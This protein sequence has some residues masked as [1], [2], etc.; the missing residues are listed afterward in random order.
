MGTTE[1]KVCVKCCNE[2]D[3]NGATYGVCPFCGAEWTNVPDGASDLPPGTM[4]Y[5]YEIIRTLGYG[6]MGTVYLAEQKSMQRQIALKVLN[7]SVTKD[8]AAVNQF[9]NEVRNTGQ[10]HH[11]NIVNAFDAGCENG[12]YFFAMQYI[13][14]ETLDLILQERKSLPEKEAL[15]ITA[16]I[17]SALVYVW[18]KHQMFHRDIKPGN[19]M[20]DDDGKAMLMDLG[21]AQ[22]IGEGNSNSESI[23]GSPYY[24]SP[25]QIQGKPLSWSTDLYSLGATLYQLITGVPPYDDKTIE[26]ILKKHCQAEFPDPAERAPGASIS[27]ET[28]ALL[29]RMMNKVPEKRFSSWGEFI[30]ELNELIALLEDYEANPEKRKVMDAATIARLKREEIKKKK[31]KSTVI[32]LS[33]VAFL[34]LLCVG[35]YIYIATTNSSKAGEFLNAVNENRKTKLDMAFEKFKEN[36]ESR[37]E[38]D[39]AL[40]NVEILANAVGVSA[41]DTEQ[42]MDK[43]RNRRAEVEKLYTN[44]TDFVKFRDEEFPAR[45]KNIEEN[46]RALASKSKL[47]IDDINNVEGL[48]RNAEKAINQQKPLHSAHQQQLKGFKTKI[49]YLKKEELNPFR[50][51]LKN[52]DEYAA[53]SRKQASLANASQIQR[54][55]ENS[56][57]T[58]QRKANRQADDANEKTRQAILAKQKAQDAARAK[59]LNDAKKPK[60]PAAA[61]RKAP[62]KKPLLPIRISQNRLASAEAKKEQLRIQNEFRDAFALL[63][64]KRAINIKPNPELLAIKRPSH[65]KALNTEMDKLL[66]I[67]EPLHQQAVDALKGWDAL[68]NETNQIIFKGMSVSATETNAE[69][70]KGILHIDRIKYGNVY[71]SETGS[72]PEKFLDLNMKDKANLARRLAQIKRFSVTESYHFFFTFGFYNLAYDACPESE[73][74]ILQKKIIDTVRYHYNLAKKRGDLPTQNRMKRDYQGVKILKSIVR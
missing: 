6:G 10:I 15:A 45:K 65:D 32:A 11:P 69:L 73:Q 38:I 41:K 26:G 51:K 22:R 49:D 5:G 14:G 7:N 53:K 33:L 17:A 59:I 57:L 20:L 42:I 74:K 47:S 63:D 54:A 13:K 64:L 35:G 34:V 23:E 43:V 70:R 36:P 62:P 8:T 67:Y 39:K 19:I 52:Q 46:I 12:I 2:F 56:V 71:F 58:E 1:K 37:I 40:K 50:I 18:N 55:T 3:Y 27:Y 21:I 4:L 16:Q 28:V 30:K 44:F 68:N 61:P 25:E 31:N 48:I 72:V 29:K 24:M 60:K 9:L 66:K